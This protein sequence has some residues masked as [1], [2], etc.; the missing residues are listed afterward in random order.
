MSH[1]RQHNLHMTYREILNKPGKTARRQ[2]FA[3][4]LDDLSEEELGY[5]DSLLERD[6]VETLPEQCWERV[7]SL[8]H[9]RIES[10]RTGGTP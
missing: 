3:D 1:A 5:I 2:A 7:N 10:V 4:F 9:L 6:M 8:L